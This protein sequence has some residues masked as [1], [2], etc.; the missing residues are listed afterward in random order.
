MAGDG[1]QPCAQG[2]QLPGVRGKTVNFSALLG[3][4]ASAAKVAVDVAAWLACLV[5]ESEQVAA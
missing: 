3:I 4:G 1:L 5:V 2:K